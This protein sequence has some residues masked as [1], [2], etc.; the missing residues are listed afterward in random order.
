[1][2]FIRIER[3]AI[4]WFCNMSVTLK[5]KTTAIDSNSDIAN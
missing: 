1:M 3:R 5:V 2:K 4:A